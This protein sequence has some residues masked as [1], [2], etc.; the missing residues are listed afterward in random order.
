MMTVQMLPIPLNWQFLLVVLMPSLRLPKELVQLIP[1]FNTTT[2][3][4]ILSD[5]N[6]DLNSNRVDW[7][8]AVSLATDDAPA[9]MLK[10]AG[11]LNKIKGK[12]V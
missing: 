9:M 2:A 5:V 7:A 6:D 11:V 8:C 4:H 3:E 12:L 10:K 1:L